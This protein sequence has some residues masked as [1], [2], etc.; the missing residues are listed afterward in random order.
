MNIQQFLDKLE[1][2]RVR[3]RQEPTLTEE[4]KSELKKHPKSE[5]AELK[6]QYLDHAKKEI[7]NWIFG[8][9]QELEADIKASDLPPEAINALLDAISDV[10]DA[11]FVASPQ[12][13]DK[14]ED[15]RQDIMELA[16]LELESIL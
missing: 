12:V 11:Q 6:K 15:L 1:L 13:L 5:R 14:I 10:K 3:G 16:I 4:Q 9:L 7:E 2:L 8:T